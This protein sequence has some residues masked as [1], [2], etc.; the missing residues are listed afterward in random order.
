MNLI[1]QIQQQYKPKQFT[2]I[3]IGG[4]TP[5]YLNDKLLNMLLRVLSKYLDKTYEFTIECNPELLTYEQAMI[6]KAN[7]VNRA[8][9]GVQTVNNTIL[10]K[11]NRQHTLKD[12]QNA[13]SN[14]KKVG[15]DNISI[16][17]IYGF[18]ELTTKD[19]LNAINFIKSQPI[20][21]VS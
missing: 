8:S 4:G 2:T 18:N 7:G 12:V 14:L 20:T 5:N 19:I 1:K 17:L 10:Y 6:M 16:D 21:H 11:F 3:Y 13:I 15:I 9:I